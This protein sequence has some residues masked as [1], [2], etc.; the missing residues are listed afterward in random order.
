MINKKENWKF[1]E[2]ET[3]DINSYNRDLEAKEINMN[4]IARVKVRTTHRLMP[5]SYRDNRITGSIVLMDENINET[6]AAGIN[7]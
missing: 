2:L 7:V 5:D 6:V 4:D 1:S 3:L